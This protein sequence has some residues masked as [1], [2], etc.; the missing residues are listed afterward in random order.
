MVFFLKIS[1]PSL[2]TSEFLLKSR[3]LFLHELI[4]KHSCKYITH[5]CLHYWSHAP[6]HTSTWLSCIL[7]SS[8]SLLRL[9]NW[10]FAST[11]F[12]SA[13]FFF[14][15]AENTCS[16]AASSSFLFISSTLWFS[17]NCPCRC[18]FLSYTSQRQLQWGGTTGQK[19]YTSFV[20]SK[21]S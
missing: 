4:V 17:V 15:S 2:K 11:H 18:A 7:V 14:A 3:P 13:C 8:T 21:S 10:S 20:L 1:K 12:S 16:L 5:I 6:S 9:P 19:E